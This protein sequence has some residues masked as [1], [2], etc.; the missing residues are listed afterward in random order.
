MAP[1][2]N[3]SVKFDANIFVGDRYMAILLL[4]D[5]AV[6]CL[7][8]P[9][10]KRFFGGL[11]PKCSLILLRPP[12]MHILDGKHAIWRIDRADWSRNATWA[13]AEESKKRKKERKKEKKLRDLTSHVCAQTTHVA[14]PPPKLS[15]GVGSRT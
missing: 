11:T 1:V 2:V 13:R 8:R 4:A 3:L 10:L 14:L 12:K 5:L 9:I 6:K 7:F 15:C